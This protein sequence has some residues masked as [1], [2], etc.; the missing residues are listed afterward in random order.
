MAAMRTTFPESLAALDRHA[1]TQRFSDQRNL[2]VLYFAAV[3]LLLE[4]LAGFATWQSSGSVRWLWMAALAIPGVVIIRIVWNLRRPVKRRR[5]SSGAESGLLEWADRNLRS[6]VLGTYVLIC[7]AV[8]LRWYARPGDEPLVALILLTIALRITISERLMILLGLLSAALLI[9]LLKP[10]TGF[11]GPTTSF[12]LQSSIYGGLTLV[13]LLLGWLFTRGFTK[14]F[15]ADWRPAQERL[16]EERRMRAELDLARSIQLSMLPRDL[17]VTRGL[18]LAAMSLPAT[19]VGGDFYDFYSRGETF[20][21]V[22]ADVAGHGVGSAIVLSGVRAAL[23]L[24]I[25]DRRDPREILERLDEL[26]RDTRTE[27]MLVTLCLVTVAA[28][29]RSAS[30]ISAGHPPVLHWRAR[31]AE[32]SV[33]LLPSLPLGTSLTQTATVANLVLEPGDRLLIHTDGA[34][35]TRNRE[36][37]ELGIERLSGILSSGSADESAEATLSRVAR[38]I[39][40][41]RGDAPQEDDV[42]MVVVRIE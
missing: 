2:V 34:Y 8:S 39:D 16:R 21:I 25:Q 12:W 10:G 29:R 7:V 30:V 23:R 6:F 17:P 14:N 37:V 3:F 33:V 22:E 40:S 24:L 18:T 38:E 42:T 19:E 9:V 26:I 32:V 28:D 4:A 11:G 31:S 1:A 27:R 13:A 20:S 5:L 41:F 15:L 35:E 36:E